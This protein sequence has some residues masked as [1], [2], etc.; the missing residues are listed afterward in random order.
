MPDEDAANRDLHRPDVGRGTCGESLSGQTG[1][2]DANVTIT[3]IDVGS[4]LV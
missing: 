1:T 3:S 4:L 2:V